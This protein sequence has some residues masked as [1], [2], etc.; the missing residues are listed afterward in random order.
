MTLMSQKIMFA[1]DLVTKSIVL[2]S[3]CVGSIYMFS[4]SLALENKIWQNNK[5]PP[6]ELK[7]INGLTLGFSGA[8]VIY[9]ICKGIGRLNW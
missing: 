1:D 2:S 4:A 5:N 9:T 8:F 3:L 6:Y 7:I